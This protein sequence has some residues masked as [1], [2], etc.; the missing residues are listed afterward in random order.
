MAQGKGAHFNGRH[1]SKGKVYSRAQHIDPTLPCMRWQATR[2]KMALGALSVA[3]SGMLVAPNVAWAAT[4]VYVDGTSYTEATGGSGSVAGKWSWDGADNMVLE[5][6]YGSQVGAD[7]DLNISLVG[8]NEVNAQGSFAGNE[9]VYVDGGDLTITGDSSDG[10]DSL[11]A[12]ATGNAGAIETYNGSITISDATVEAEALSDGFDF[13]GD[14]ADPENMTVTNQGTG[15]PTG[16]IAAGDLSISNATVNA[17]VGGGEWG[18]IGTYG[19]DITIDNSK[20]QATW[21]TEY[22]ADASGAIYADD[23]NVYIRNGSD[24]TAFEKNQGDATTHGIYASIT[25]DTVDGGKVVISNSKVKATA[26]NTS[27]PAWTRGIGAFSNKAGKTPSISIDRSTIDVN[28]SGPAILAWSRGIDES[29]TLSITNSTITSPAGAHVQDITYQPQ[30]GSLFL[31]QTLGTGTGV[32]DNPEST[33][34]VK[35]VSILADK[36]SP[37]PT[38]DPTPASDPVVEKAGIGLPTTG[39]AT[40]VAASAAAAVGAGALVA[41]AIVFLRRCARRS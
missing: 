28:A 17:V 4:A 1:V 24:V 41:G 10:A 14:P 25:T 9:A 5:G 6:F 34:I 8:T 26:L 13:T 21:V 19:G 16:I 36:I 38:P 30:F 31:G 33:D 29:G 37:V 23:G 3:M 22:D 40:G 27:E 35:E 2:R 7:G 12:T 20:V 32:I 39:D 15:D 11:S 18:P